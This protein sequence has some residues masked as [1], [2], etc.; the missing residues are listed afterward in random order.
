MVPSYGVIIQVTVELRRKY[1]ILQKLGTSFLCIKQ[2]EGWVG[3]AP[4]MLTIK[5]QASTWAPWE[6]CVLYLMV[7]VDAHNDWQDT[8]RHVYTVHDPDSALERL[9]VTLLPTA[10]PSTCV[11]VLGLPT[12]MPTLLTFLCLWSSLFSFGEPHLKCKGLLQPPLTC[13]HLGKCKAWCTQLLGKSLAN[14]VSGTPYLA[15][16]IKT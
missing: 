6:V 12:C 7:S 13:G 9:L 1:E 14:K 10:K 11:V 16:V 5:A 15:D 2:G 3:W 4:H 8:W